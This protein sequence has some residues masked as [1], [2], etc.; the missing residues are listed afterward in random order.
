MTFPGRYD[1]LEK[2][3]EFV[4]RAARQ[5]GLADDD[6]YAVE[7]SVDEACSNIIDHAYGGEDRGEINCCT[8]VEPDCLQ[9]TLHDH[10]RSFDPTKIT[11]P[12][13]DVPISKLKE[14]GAG[15]FLMRCLMDEI[16]YEADPEKGNVM[17]LEKRRSL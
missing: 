16:R 6:V 15:L 8:E 9:V 3:A 4:T 13:C 7:L 10:G 11:I 14:R 12:I 5:A 1:S 2:I 17:I